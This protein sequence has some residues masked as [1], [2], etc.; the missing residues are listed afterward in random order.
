[1]II[2]ETHRP[3]A[4]VAAAADGRRNGRGDTGGRG[5]WP[6]VAAPGAPL[7]AASSG[8]VAQ[9]LARTGG[10]CTSIRPVGPDHLGHRSRLTC[11]NDQKKP[12]AAVV[13]CA[14]SSAAPALAQDFEP[15]VRALDSARA[16][17]LLQQS[18]RVVELKQRELEQAIA[19]IKEVEAETQRFRE[20]KSAN[21]GFSVILAV[22]DLQGGAPTRDLPPAAS[23]ALADMS[24]FLPYKS[25][26]LIDARWILGSPRSTSLIR[27]PENREY[28]LE[29][30]TSA[31][32]DSEVQIDF[33]LRDPRQAFPFVAGA[34]FATARER[35]ASSN[36]AASSTRPSTWTSAKRS[37]SAP[38]GCRA[39]RRSSCC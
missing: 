4:L 6:A 30:R 7:G 35:S 27:G 29:L 17:V 16:R 11:E 18:H 31:R 24:Q 23:K 12:L 13:A 1:M 5:D 20:E 34:A 10:R 3:A 36:R 22:G 33:N 25:Y 15:A 37:S 38:R 19:R 9:T 28:E 2:A 14:L 39:T 21:H 8:R 26:E 32:S